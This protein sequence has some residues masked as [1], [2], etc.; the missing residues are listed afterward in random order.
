MQKSGVKQDPQ[1]PKAKNS[2]LKTSTSPITMDKRS[3]EW[4]ASSAQEPNQIKN[5]FGGG[6]LSVLRP[7]SSLRTW[8]MSLW[9]FTH[10]LQILECGTL[11]IGVHRCSIIV[12]HKN[13][14]CEGI[15]SMWNRGRMKLDD[16]E[17]SLEP[18]VQ[19]F[20]S[21]VWALISVR[22]CPWKKIQRT[23]LFINHQNRQSTNKLALNPNPHWET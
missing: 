19:Q 11:G 2:F 20:Y 12:I 1:Q 22:K 6:Q 17:I 5:F 4:I 8:L 13:W 21:T 3:F 15:G 14:A 10:T 23:T 7:L 16:R 9:H 18:L